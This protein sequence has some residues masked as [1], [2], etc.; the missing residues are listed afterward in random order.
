MWPG[1]S[2][3]V[4]YSS[5]PVLTDAR[6][7]SQKR[8]V[9]LW[10]SWLGDEAMTKEMTEKSA[11]PGAIRMARSRARRRNR[12]RC[13]TIEVSDR[14]IAA[15]VRGGHLPPEKRDDPMAIAKAVHGLLDFVA[16]QERW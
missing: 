6:D 3:I 11:S 4:Y 15:F 5:A 14:E 10:L 1:G 13:V 8:G 9:E 7:K 12:F 2:A 16:A